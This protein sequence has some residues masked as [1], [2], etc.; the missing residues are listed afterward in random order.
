MNLIHTS[1]SGVSAHKR[2]FSE[3]E[4]SESDDLDLPAL[5][6]LHLSDLQENEQPREDRYATH[7]ILIGGHVLLGSLR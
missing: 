4:P 1:S 6:R 7:G 2:T 5:K 3:S